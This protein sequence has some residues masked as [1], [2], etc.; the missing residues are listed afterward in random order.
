M[1]RDTAGLTALLVAG[2]RR[3][4]DPVFRH[5]VLRPAAVAAAALVG[6]AALTL[7]PTG[8]LLLWQARV[9]H[10]RAEAAATATYVGSPVRDGPVTFVVHELRCGSDDATT[11]GRR[12]EVTLGVRNDGTHPV[13]VP[14]EA[15]WL[16]VA[17]GARHQAINVDDI[18]LDE[19]G[20]GQSATA[21]LVF[22]L[23][24]HATVTHLEV[25]ADA[26]SHGV[27]VDVA[28]Q[29]LPLLD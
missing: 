17:E 16:L 20:P 13:T 9:E 19:L 6:L 27:P 14:A 25:H 12:C 15:Q 29:S 3:L 23:P 4:R 18:P 24:R 8:L 2:Y 10:Q 7:G 26:Y 11:F 21:V 5:R 22:D 1:A 28:G